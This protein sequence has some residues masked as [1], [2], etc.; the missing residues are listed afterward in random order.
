MYSSEGHLFV[1]AFP[2]GMLD[3]FNEILQLEDKKDLIWR[4]TTS[5]DVE[6]AISTGFIPMV[7]PHEIS[8]RFSSIPPL[9]RDNP[10][11]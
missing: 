2:E 6:F 8:D 5:D 3:A 10:V 1:Y 11:S 9:Q 7:I 4:V